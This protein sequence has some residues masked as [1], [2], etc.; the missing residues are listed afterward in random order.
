MKLTY[1]DKLEIYQLRKQGCL[2]LSWVKPMM[3]ILEIYVTWLSLW[4]D[5]A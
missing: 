4:T 2:G 1:E 5:M 3:S